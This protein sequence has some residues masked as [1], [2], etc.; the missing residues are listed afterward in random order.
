V[1]FALWL[2]ADPETRIRQAW[3]AKAVRFNLLLR[4]FKDGPK[5]FVDLAGHLNRMRF[6]ELYVQIKN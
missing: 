5:W 6:P 3:L 1:L 4:D 2:L